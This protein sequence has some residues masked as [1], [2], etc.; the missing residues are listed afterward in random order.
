MIVELRGKADSLKILDDELVSMLKR[1]PEE[2][3]VAEEEIKS[4]MDNYLAK[5]NG[6]CN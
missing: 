3:G 5:E 2:K 1:W 4:E 6:D